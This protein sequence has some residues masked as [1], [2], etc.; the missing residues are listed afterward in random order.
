M[1]TVVCS[2]IDKVMINLK[3]EEFV[4]DGPPLQSLQQLIQWVGDFVLYLLANLPNQVRT[5][6]PRW[7]RRSRWPSG[8]PWT[9]VSSAPAGLHGAAGLRLHEGRRLPGD[10]EGDAGDDP[11]LGPPEGRLPA[12][13][14]RHLRQPG[15]H[16]AALQAAHQAVALL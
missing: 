11:D 16:A 14:H 8:T 1:M 4:L 9:Q 13:L 6:R 7:T 12:H 2:D 3:T 5:R 15:Q 10:A